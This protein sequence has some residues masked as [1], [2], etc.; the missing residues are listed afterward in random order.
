MTGLDI[1]HL[2]IKHKKMVCKLCKD[3][4]P[5]AEEELVED[6]Y[7]YAVMKLLED[8]THVTTGDMFVTL[9][10]TTMDWVGRQVNQD[11][12][13]RKQIEGTRIPRN[14]IDW[15]LLDPRFY[16][17]CTEAQKRIIDYKQGI[18][19]KK[20]ALGNIKRNKDY[21]GATAYYT[22]IKYKRWYKVIQLF[23]KERINKVS[24][25]LFS[26][27]LAQYAEG[28]SPQAIAKSLNKKNTYIS[29]VLFRY[30][31]KWKNE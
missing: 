31:H 6:G 26:E 18:I 9:V 13:L 22:F 7:S 5:P 2:S 11:T 12:Q 23:T 10:H 25:P 28:H 15:K 14:S 4:I 21:I 27:I 30:I 1:A 19:P 24:E 17:H 3:K 29:A 20:Q 16:N 8:P